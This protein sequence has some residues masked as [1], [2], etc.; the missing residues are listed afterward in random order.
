MKTKQPS[1]PNWK[2]LSILS[3]RCHKARW[4]RL[5]S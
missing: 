3:A 5:A 4:R 1:N 2:V